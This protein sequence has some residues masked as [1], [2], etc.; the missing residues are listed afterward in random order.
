[1]KTF[2]VQI[3]TLIEVSL[4]RKSMWKKRIGS[5][6]KMVGVRAGTWIWRLSQRALGLHQQGLCEICTLRLLKWPAGP[7]TCA[8]GA[9]QPFP[10]AFFSSS[11]QS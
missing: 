2:V 6:G 9:L 8:G 11:L 1:M 5:L 3:A 7:G 4:G 10:G